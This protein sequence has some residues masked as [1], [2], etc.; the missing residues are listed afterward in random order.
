[1]MDPE[2][3]NVAIS[4]GKQGHVG[5]SVCRVVKLSQGCEILLMFVLTTNVLTSVRVGYN[6]S[7]DSCLYGS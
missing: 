7:Y 3:E 5:M 6:L 1:M 2:D 4:A